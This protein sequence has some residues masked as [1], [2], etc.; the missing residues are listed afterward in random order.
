MEGKVVVV[1]ASS[2][3]G[4]TRAVV[5]AVSKKGALVVLLA[6]KT[7]GVDRS[8]LG[9]NVVVVDT[10]ACGLR[11]DLENVRAVASKHGEVC[12]WVNCLW[13]LPG[14]TTPPSSLAEGT[15]QEMF[16]DIVVSG[17][18][19]MQVALECFASNG[20]GGRIV[21]LT[22]EII[23]TQASAGNSALR[24]SISMLNTLTDGFMMEA[25]QKNPPIGIS[26]VR[27]DINDE[28]DVVMNTAD[29]VAAAIGQLSGQKAN[30][31]VAL[32]A[33]TRLRGTR[34][35]VGAE[36]EPNYDGVAKKRQRLRS[37]GEM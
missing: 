37:S 11:S 34:A 7:S 30:G 23:R 21:N 9:P 20:K 3:E 15:L 16:S 22:S 18:L 13:P 35:V 19:G 6:G 2:L 1:V 10:G 4:R 8:S 26:F 12:G 24:S 36:R 32:A 17:L 14:S 28:L 29:Q 33:D 5:T 25:G 27:G 31:Q